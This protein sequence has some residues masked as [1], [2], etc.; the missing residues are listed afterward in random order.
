MVGST[1]RTHELRV[2]LLDEPAEFLCDLGREALGQEPFGE[3]AIHEEARRR[4]GRWSP[5]RAGRSPLEVIGRH[6][7]RNRFLESAHFVERLP[8]VSQ[9]DL[10]ATEQGYERLE[11]SLAGV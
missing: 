11:P 4:S 5:R 6:K 2:G 9:M 7:R 10:W 1:E 3:L 8:C